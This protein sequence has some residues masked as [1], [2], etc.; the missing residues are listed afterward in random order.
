[1]VFEELDQV[2]DDFASFDKQDDQLDD[3]CEYEGQDNRWENQ[4]H[5]LQNLFVD[6]QFFSIVF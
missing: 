6:R 4:G 5:P 3:H 2:E 1:M